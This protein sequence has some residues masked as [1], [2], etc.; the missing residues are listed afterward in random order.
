MD[1]LDVTAGSRMMWFDKEDDRCIFLDNRKETHELC[2]GRTLVIDPDVQA[3]FR[4]MPFPDNTFNLVVFDP[5]HLERLGESSWT[6]AKYGTL[7]PNWEEVLTDGFTEC[8]RVLKPGGVL[9]FK[10]NEY[11][12]P[13]KRV[14]DCT[15]HSP[16]FG[17]VTGRQSK[18]HWC[19]FLKEKK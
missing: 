9:I 15:T 11:Q 3:D 16:L 6:N 17:H 8:F 2:D 10:W 14:L 5:P 19:T 1:V 13:V 7:L 4:H 18:T 12:I